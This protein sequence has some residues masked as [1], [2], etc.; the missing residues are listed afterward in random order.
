MGSEGQS[1]GM[2]V[3]HLWVRKA[4]TSLGKGEKYIFLMSSSS[5][6]LDIYM[7]VTD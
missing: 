2:N 5:A 1:D 6:G 7:Q 4:L 3:S